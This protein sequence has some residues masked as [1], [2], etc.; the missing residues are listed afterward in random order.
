MASNRDESGA[1]FGR[2]L[3][4]SQSRRGEIFNNQPKVRGSSSFF[5][6]A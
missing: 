1:V 5:L 6:T 3:E 4:P 2:S